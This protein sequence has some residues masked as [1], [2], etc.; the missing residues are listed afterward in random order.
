MNRIYHLIII[1]AALAVSFSCTDYQEL[2]VP[3]GLSV[4]ATM[5]SFSPGAASKPVT[6]RC[7]AKWTVASKP[8]WVNVE[9]I[10]SSTVPYQW[11]V[12]FAVSANR[13][14]DR[15]GVV[16]FQS[17]SSS[18]SISVAQEGE[19]GKYVPVQSVSIPSTLI[20]TEGDSNKKLTVNILPS[21]ASVKTVTW[22]SS[23][24]NIVSV[25]GDGVLTATSVGSAVITVTTD[26][27]GKTA[28]CVVT[29]NEKVIP[30]TGVSLDKTSL[31]LTEEETYS[32]TATVA[33]ANA[34]DKSV[35]WTS[36]NTAV[37]TVSSAGVVTAVKAGSATISVTTTDGGKKAT[38]A[39]TV[40]P[41]HVTGVTLNMTSLTLTIGETETLTATVSP[42]NATDKSVTWSSG[43][44]SVATVSSSGVVTAR[45]VGNA[46]ITVTTNDG[47][48]K[49]T[50]TVT[51]NPIHVTGVALN[52]TGLTLIVGET[53]TLTATVSPADATDKSV[54]WS[55]SNTS[56]AT[57]S[58]SGV[59]TAIKA[60]SATITVNTN[61]G[62][63]TATC[64][65][66]VNLAQVAVDLGLPSGLK[67]ASCNIGAT[68]PEGYGDYYAWGETETKE[69]ASLETYKWGS[70]SNL[71][72]FT[73]YNTQSQYGTVDNKAV[74]DPEDD[75]AYVK[76]GGKWRMPTYTEWTE[77]RTKCSWKETTQNGVYGRKVTGP[78]GNSIFLPAAGYQSGTNL[79]NV[80][81]NGYYFSSSLDTDD[82]YLAW[83]VT[84][85]SSVNRYFYIRGY[86]FSVR[87]VY[88]DVVSV[89]SVS[90]NTTSIS[91]TEG[92]TQTLTATVSPSNATNKYVLWSSSDTSVATVSSSGG[93]TAIK[94]GSATITVETID[95]GKTASC[96]VTV[97]PRVSGV[98]LDNSS[99]SLTVGGTQTL[100]ATVTPADALDKSVT[101]SSSNTSVATVSSNGVVTAKDVGNATITVTTNDG[102]KTATCAV[103]VTPMSVTGVSLN[104]NSLTMYENDSETLIATV[105]PSNATNKSVSWSSS[106]PAVANVNAVG[107]VS[108]LAAGSAVITVTTD[109]GGKTATC[110]VTVKAD[111][112]GAVDLGLSVKW[113]SFNYGASS[114]TAT[115]GY[116]MWGDPTGTAV[117]MEYTP[118]SV[119]SVSGTQYD[120]VRKNWGGNWRIPT[121]SEINELYSNCTW[122]QTTVSGVSVLKVTGP[123]GAS[124]Y[125]PFTGYA[126]PASGPAGTVK[127]TDSS[128]AYVMSADSYADS[129]G[130]FVY[131]YYFTPSGG[132]NS[133]SYNAEF[134]KFPIRPVR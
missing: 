95:G 93:V 61:D 52:K 54:T 86:G 27:G 34:T 64:S 89:Q 110:S 69:N 17:G 71:I 46:T 56:V 92:K 57:V 11:D 97:K 123:N 41:I 39:V 51:V 128:N 58:S 127:I 32:L 102:G 4:N 7:G 62:G 125:L 106:N 31:T 53:E 23:A 99:I 20:L 21:N 80:G 120:I 55:S 38:C 121:R 30:V 84:F 15:E 45:A 25:D 130:R 9:S 113:A 12:T 26:D 81:S 19:K 48:K 134:V 42:A 66:T 115:G 77:L 43:N 16:T 96:A 75:V 8:E 65:L 13:E 14:Y 124:I 103:T 37:A 35:T 49:A 68:K 67:W 104:K 28:T 76:L 78:N 82:P 109:D 94:A 108:A 72:S 44:T 22:Q 98:S 87:P 24:P 1:A 18:E 90:L 2:D 129:Y 132:R 117:A 107:H 59:V 29:V 79:N 91:L 70:G 133:V 36:S 105:T 10:I 40:N 119:N 3:E 122:T 126:M 50:C 83:F 100:T 33:P 47:G 101:W 116:Y 112:Y 74:L 114:V 111:P 6:V 60:G 63:K 118:P 88:G 131:V 85:S 5:W 73:K